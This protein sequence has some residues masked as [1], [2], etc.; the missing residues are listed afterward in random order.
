MF[1]KPKVKLCGKI[2]HF[3]VEVD[4]NMKDVQKNLAVVGFEPRLFVGTSSIA[5]NHYTKEVRWDIHKQ[6]RELT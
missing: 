5:N 3:F 4:K 6:K 2:E 1:E